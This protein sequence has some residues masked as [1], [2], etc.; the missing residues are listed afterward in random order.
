MCESTGSTGTGWGGWMALPAGEYAQPGGPWLDL[1]HVLGPEV[2]R[3]LL[4]PQPS[5][6]R[7]KSLPA[8]PLNMTEMQMVVHIGTHVDAPRHFFNDGPAFHEI[9]LDRL[10]GTGVVLHIKKGPGEII[11]ESDLEPFSVDIKPGDIVALETGWAAF[12]QTPAY[13]DHPYLS[14]CAA[15][16]LV[17]RKIKLLACDLPTPDMPVGRRPLGYN[18]PAH[19]ILLGNG[20]L[21][22]EN[23]TGLAPLA[24]ERVEFIFSA[25]NI[26]DS[27]G[28]PARVLARRLAHTVPKGG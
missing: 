19:H 11:F 18:W 15:Q 23:L 20:V 24:G 13:H 28:A 21:V 2:P 16:W 1:S 7:L 8:D 10:T 3:A 4:F 26:E 27:D 14:P 6:R 9:P 25:L 5:F 12:A 22:A 17:N